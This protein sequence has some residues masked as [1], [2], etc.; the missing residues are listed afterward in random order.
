MKNKKQIATIIR[1]IARIWGSLSLI[2]MI[3]FVCAHLYGSITGKGESLGQM[4]ISFLFFPIST[5]IGLAIAWKRDGLGGL[6][7][8]CGIIGFHIIRPDLLLNL[9][10]DGLAVPGLF[11]IIYWL[12]TR[13]P[14]KKSEEKIIVMI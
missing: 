6:I 1:W 3:F 9:M 7:T 11:F 13:S 10:I 4:S 5:I 8:I 2:I 12:L 14:G